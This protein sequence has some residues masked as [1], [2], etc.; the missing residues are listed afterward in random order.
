MNR[1]DAIKA[2][3]ECRILIDAVDRRIISLINE[4]SRVVEEIGRIKRAA[5]L[6]IYEPRRED[7]VYRNVVENNEGP[8]AEDA[9]RRI[10]E[11]IIDEM[12]HLQRTRMEENGDK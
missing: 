4:R 10:F 6:P 7:E 9:V 3:A 11:R 12:R 2:L 1:D 8:L 5:R